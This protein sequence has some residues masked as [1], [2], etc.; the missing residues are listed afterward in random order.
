MQ[1]WSWQKKSDDDFEGWQKLNGAMG[2]GGTTKLR[3][4]LILS[5]KTSRKP[6]LFVSNAKLLKPPPHPYMS[7]IAFIE[8]CVYTRHHVM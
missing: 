4:D 5:N 2:G 3:S 6:G 1:R 8:L 7:D